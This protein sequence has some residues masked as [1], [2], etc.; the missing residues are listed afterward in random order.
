[1]SLLLYL[2]H[3]QLQVV[4]VWQTNLVELL[5][6]HSLA[7]SSPSFYVSRILYSYENFSKKY[8]SYFDVDKDHF[9]QWKEDVKIVPISD[10]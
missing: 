10:I 7:P 5:L 3:A 9:T 1:M 6:I 2:M 4:I 8:S